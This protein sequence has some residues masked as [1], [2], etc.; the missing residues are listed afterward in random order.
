[1]HDAYNDDDEDGGDDDTADEDDDEDEV[2]TYN[3]II[4]QRKL[5]SFHPQR[6]EAGKSIFAFYN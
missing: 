1:M 4:A 6:G 3:H 2:I 5:T